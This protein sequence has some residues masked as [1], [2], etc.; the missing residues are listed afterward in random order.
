MDPAPCQ[1]PG[2][3][4]IVRKIIDFSFARFAQNTKKSTTGDFFSILFAKYIPKNKGHG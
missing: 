4:R 3:E 2:G 1:Q